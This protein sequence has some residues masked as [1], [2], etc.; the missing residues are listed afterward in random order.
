MATSD[1]PK[2]SYK[3]RLKFGANAGVYILFVLGIFILIE[4]I[5]SQHFYRLDVTRSGR[6]TLAPQTKKIMRALDKKIRITSFFRSSQEN[7]QAAFEELIDQYSYLSD[8]ITYRNIDPDRNPGETRRYKVTTYGTVVLECGESEKRIHE[9]TEE[10]I[11][12]AIIK[13]TKAGKKKVFFL[14]GHGERSID[15]MKEEGFQEAREAIEQANYETKELTLLPNKKVLEGVDVLII[16]GPQKDFQRNEVKILSA[17][18]RDGGKILLMLDPFKAPSLVAFAR[19][20]GVQMK[21]DIIIDQ[22]SRFF[23]ADL[24]MPIVSKYRRHP[25]TKDFALATFFP[26][27]RSVQPIKNPE[28][29]GTR[30]DVLLTTSPDSWAETN[31]ALLDQGKAN[32]DRDADEKGPVSI[33]VALTVKHSS[34][35]KAGGP[36]VGKEGSNTKKKSGRMVILGDSDFATNSRINMVGNKDFFL[37]VVSWL[38]EDTDL[39]SIRPRQGGG[40][41]PSPLTLSQQRLVFILPVLVWPMFTV[42]LGIMIFRHRKRLR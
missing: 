16:A 34:A 32:F 39:I 20:F 8:K 17:F 14:S 25:I 29:T 11:T 26:L 9:K 42:F 19:K 12:N 23:G 7:E 13:I 18:L 4:M 1:T 24:T 15:S 3:R 33:G 2:V 31:K 27:A 38:A 22:E 5:S 10:R 36:L 37:N 6:Y 40:A 41:I 30:V 35:K 21:E 28:N